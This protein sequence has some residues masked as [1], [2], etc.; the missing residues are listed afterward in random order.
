ME[1]AICSETWK[2]KRFAGK[3]NRFASKKK[4]RF[5]LNMEKDRSF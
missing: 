5:A 4:I 2:E 3:I 1:K